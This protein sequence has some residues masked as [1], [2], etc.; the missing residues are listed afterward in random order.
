MD[1]YYVHINENN[2][3]DGYEPEI[4]EVFPGTP[5]TERFDEFYTSR[6]IALLPENDL[7]PVGYIYDSVTGEFTPPPETPYYPPVET[8]PQAIEMKI[9]EINAA[10]NAAIITGF[11]YN[12]SHYSL[13]ETDQINILAYM[14]AAKAGN[15]IAYHADNEECRIYSAN[16]FA[17]IGAE[18]VKFKA[19][20][21][22]YCN[23]LK[24]QVRGMADIDA[25]LAVKYGETE[26]TGEYLDRMN[27]IMGA[28]G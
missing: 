20:H 23:L 19:Y 15:S 25:V 7:P 9:A 13:A 22:T 21:T 11:D 24:F 1:N 10:C 5:V 14:D 12:Q 8:L 6:L 18:A 3:V 4:N 2:R 16:E 26:L 28:F 27:E 17:L